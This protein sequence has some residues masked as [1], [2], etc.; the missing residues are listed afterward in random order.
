M[1]IY[2]SAGI[3]Y[4]IVEGHDLGQIVSVNGTLYTIEFMA[5][6]CANASDL[7]AVFHK[8][9]RYANMKKFLQAIAG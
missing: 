6:P 5:R 4:Q 7:Y 8:G 1:K 3:Q 9:I 2:T